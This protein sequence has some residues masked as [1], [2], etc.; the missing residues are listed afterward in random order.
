M[1]QVQKRIG[2]EKLHKVPGY[3]V[4]VWSQY[5]GDMCVPPDVDQNEIASYKNAYNA[6]KKFAEIVF[7]KKLAQ[8]IEQIV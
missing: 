4:S 5:E 6:I 3:S 2:S 7:A 1:V 8:D